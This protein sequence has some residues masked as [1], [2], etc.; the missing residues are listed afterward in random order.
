MLSHKQRT[1]RNI[2]MQRR[3]L[4]VFLV[5]I[6]VKANTALLKLVLLYYVQFG[7]LFVGQHFA[8]PNIHRF[9]RVLKFS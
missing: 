6:V 7:A 4:H 5:E 2:I 3:Y 1:K 8:I 9:S